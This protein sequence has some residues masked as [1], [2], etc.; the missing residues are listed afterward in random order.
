[1][2]KVALALTF[3]KGPEVAGWVTSMGNWLDELVPA[4]DDIPLVWDHFVMEFTLQYWDS[5]RQQRACA[6]LE[7]CKMQFPLVGQYIA[8]FEDIGKYIL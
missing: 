2:R 8:K 4:N 1:M 5:Q 6:Q 3:M 7:A